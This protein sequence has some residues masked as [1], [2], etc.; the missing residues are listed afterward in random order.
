ML[1]HKNSKSTYLHFKSSI[2]LRPEVVYRQPS[3]QGDWIAIL[4]EIKRFL[5]G[6]RQVTFRGWEI[7]PST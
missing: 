4:I 7:P 6:Y 3:L 1:R 2:Q 5:M